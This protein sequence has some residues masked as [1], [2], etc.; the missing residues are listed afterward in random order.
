[1]SQWRFQ[2]I[3]DGAQFPGVLEMNCPH[4]QRPMVKGT[5]GLEYTWWGL[6]LA[7]FSALTLFFRAP[8]RERTALVGISDTKDAFRCDSCGT[9]VLV[10]QGAADSPCLSCSAT[11]P[12]GSNTCPQCGWSYEPTGRTADPP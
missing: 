9:V 7:G 1:M 2:P 3:T 4:C 11:I 10:G 5:V 8:G 12:A 6:M